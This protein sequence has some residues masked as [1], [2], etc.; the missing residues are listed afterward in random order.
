MWTQIAGCL[1]IKVSHE[2]TF[3]LLAGT[4]VSSEILTGR[5]RNQLPHSPMRFCR[6]H[7]RATRT[8]FS[9][10]LPHDLATG[11]PQVSNPRESE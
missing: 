3:K 2:V 1:W 7:I 6:F 8:F 11:V 4:V 9:K 10:G 5:R